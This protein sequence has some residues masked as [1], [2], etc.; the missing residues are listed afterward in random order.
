MQLV[1]SQE[2]KASIIRSF[3]LI[4]SMYATLF[5]VACGGC[6]DDFESLSSCSQ[7][8]PKFAK[9]AYN[10]PY[11][12]KGTWYKPQPHYNIDEEGIASY[13]GG[14]DV[15]H[16]RKTSNGEIFDMNEVS[17]AH[18]TAPIPCVLQV[19]NLENGRSLKV[20]V[21][22]RG[23][24]IDGRII[25][26]SRRTAQLL[27]FY[28]QGTTRVHV[29][30]L[31][32]ETMLL[33]QGQAESIEP[34]LTQQTLLAQNVPQKSK[35]GKQNSSKSQAP[36]NHEPLLLA[37]KEELAKPSQRVHKKTE[38][39]RKTDTFVQKV[40]YNSSKSASLPTIYKKTSLQDNNKAKYELSAASG[41]SKTGVNKNVFI[42]AGTFINPQHAQQAKVL[43]QRKLSSMPVRLETVKFS[44][45]QLYR[46]VVGPC[47]NDVQARELVNH[48]KTIGH[49]MSRDSVSRD[50]IPKN[51]IIVFNG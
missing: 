45:K 32:P 19:T 11:Q 27:G 22:D 34:G 48:I 47:R 12:I 3:A 31:M 15:F 26:V 43:I 9:K 25:D 24:F 28:K 17:A 30:T 6:Y 23:P 42:Q 50:S 37:L 4:L 39:S 16:G 36:Q 46:V 35:N 5:L 7:V 33:V 1:I 14:T 38:N 2:L 8:H 21:N 41:S 13:Y 20:K 49:S 18:K 29:K 51:S 40:S 44:N 10:K